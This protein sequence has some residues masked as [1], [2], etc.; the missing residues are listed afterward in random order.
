MRIPTLFDK[1]QR[2]NIHALLLHVYHDDKSIV[3]KPNEHYYCSFFQREKHKYKYTIEETTPYVAN[4]F[5]LRSSLR[6][7]FL[8]LFFSPLSSSNQARGNLE[9]LKFP[10]HECTASVHGQ[11]RCQTRGRT[12]IERRNERRRKKE[13]KKE[14]E[15]EEEERLFETVNRRLRGSRT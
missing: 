6:P 15:E 11:T 1:L 3:S 7:T 13:K 14:E 5:F 4:N 2:K 9:I 8:F 10:V 12:R